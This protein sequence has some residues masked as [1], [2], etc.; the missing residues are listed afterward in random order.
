MK[1]EEL[2]EHYYNLLLSPSLREDER[3]I[4]LAY[5]Q[6]LVISNRKWKNRFLTMVEDIR[7]LSLQK[8]GEEA[9]S[10][11]LADFYKKVAFIAKTEEEKARGLASL[12]NFFH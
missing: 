4:L 10:S 1:E 3:K 5:K 7:L 2:L 9:L 11:D 6:D 8:I 12:G